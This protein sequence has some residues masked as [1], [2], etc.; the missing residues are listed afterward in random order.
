MKVSIKEK[1][2]AKH[3][4]EIDTVLKSSLV[5]DYF[6]KGRKVFNELKF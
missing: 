2:G 3:L 5:F 4:R 1:E 6:L